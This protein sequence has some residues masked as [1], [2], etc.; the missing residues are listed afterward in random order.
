MYLIMQAHTEMFPSV[1]VHIS[2][3]A[4]F[5]NMLILQCLII[6]KLMLQLLF[7]ALSFC[8]A[9]FFHRAVGNHVIFKIVFQV[10]VIAVV[11]G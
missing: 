10:Q 4:F 8:T 3:L 2:S 9:A 7:A 11:S 5:L 1:E 6:F